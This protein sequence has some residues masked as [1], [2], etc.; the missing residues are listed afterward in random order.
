V[1][2]P[3]FNQDG[4]R[5]IFFQGTYTNSFSGNPVITPRYNYN[6]IMYRLELNDPRLFLPAP[7]YR[8][9]D[10]RY[11]MREG[12]VAAQAWDQ[13]ASVPFFALAQ[14]RR[15]AG[16]IPIADLF[17]ALPYAMQAPDSAAG[18]WICKTMDKTDFTL[19]ISG[20]DGSIRLDI[21]GEQSTK[22]AYNKDFLETEVTLGGITYHLTGLYSEGTLA[23]SWKEDGGGTFTCT[24]PTMERWQDSSALVPLYFYDG[25]YTT[26]PKAETQPIARVWRNPLSGLP[27]DREAAA[28]Q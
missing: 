16:T 25:K 1:S 19:A 21:L 6:Q 5:V 15:R 9:Q 18:D 17:Y 13:V 28:T 11:Q 4:G 12:V 10:G 7:V 24:R 2:Y 22:G 26:V 27:L 23:G 14:D 20:R 3:F 8:L